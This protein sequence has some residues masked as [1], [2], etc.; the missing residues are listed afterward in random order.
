MLKY[1]EYLNLNDS[2][3]F[4]KALSIYQMI[5]ESIDSKDAD[6]TLLWNDVI[7]CASEYV[8]TRNEWALMSSTEKMEKG[9]ARTKKHNLFISSL[10]VLV[11]YMKKMDWDT[12]WHDNLRDGENTSRKKL[13]DFAGYLLL[14][15]TLSNR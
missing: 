15:G 14:F 2:L 5:M 12:D 13:G 8:K 4:E 10:D 9:A 11:R 6:F 3:S 1:N 7:Y